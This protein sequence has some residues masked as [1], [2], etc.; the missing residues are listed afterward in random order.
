MPLFLRCPGDEKSC[1]VPDIHQPLLGQRFSTWA[2]N[3]Q[4]R[5]GSY[6]DCAQPS[7]IAAPVAPN[8]LSFFVILPHVSAPPQH[9]YHHL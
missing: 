1:A 9:C 4:N 2:I 8:R 7:E 3:A 6:H 5:R